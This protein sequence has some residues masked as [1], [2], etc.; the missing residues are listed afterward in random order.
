MFTLGARGHLPC[1]Y[2][3]ITLWF[4]KQCGQPS[5]SGHMLSSFTK[6]PSIWSQCAL[7]FHAGHIVK[8][9]I[10]VA[11]GHFV[12]ELPGFFHDFVYNV[13][14]IC[15]SHSLR[16]LS[17]SVQWC[18]HK[19]FNPTLNH[20]F[21]SLLWNSVILRIYCEYIKKNHPGKFWSHNWVL[22]ERTLNEWL[23]CIVVRATLPT[24][25][26]V[27]WRLTSLPSPTSA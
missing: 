25:L 7:W 26:P 19:V 10:K 21:E 22:F 15:L 20:F 9:P 3:V 27:S 11:T 8:V 4:F 2:I 16:V 12:K 23:R 1:G 14:S 17:K 6:C 24:T 13:S 5:A 18:G